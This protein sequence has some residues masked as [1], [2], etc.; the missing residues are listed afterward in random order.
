M[1]RHLG[2][3]RADDEPLP[4]SVILESNG[5][6]DAIWVLRAIDDCPEIRLFAVRCVRQIQHTLNDTRLLNGLDVGERYAVGDATAAE[7]KAALDAALDA[8][9]AA[10][11]D[12]AWD[13]A[14]EVQRMDFI[15]IFCS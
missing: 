2:K 3:T 11:L 15:D 14:W 7:L 10:T 8:A 12:A 1:L 13:A 5:I 4:L 6:K 9:R